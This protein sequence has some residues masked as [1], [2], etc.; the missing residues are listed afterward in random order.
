MSLK[1]KGESGWPIAFG[2][3]WKPRTLG[4]HLDAFLYPQIQMG[5][6]VWRELLVTKDTCL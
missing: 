4:R 6:I 2:F 3:L 1:V 5:F